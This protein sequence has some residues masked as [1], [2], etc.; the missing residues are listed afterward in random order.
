MR[1]PTSNKMREPTWLTRRVYGPGPTDAT[2]NHIGSIRFPVYSMPDPKP[3]LSSL[4]GKVLLFSFMRTDGK[5]VEVYCCRVP[6]LRGMREVLYIKSADDIEELK[7]WAIR[8]S[9]LETEKMD[10]LEKQSAD[11]GGAEKA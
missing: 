8:L 4:T 2:R 3:T 6:D 5:E 9:E 1:E 7:R 10:A 11:E